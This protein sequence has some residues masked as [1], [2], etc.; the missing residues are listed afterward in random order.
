M[1]LN[2]LIEIRKSKWNH[3]GSK[4]L[5]LTNVDLHPNL[6]DAGQKL[7]VLEKHILE[8]VPLG[9]LNVYLEVVDVGAQQRKA[10]QDAAEVGHLEWGSGVSVTSHDVMLLVT[11]IQYHFVESTCPLS[12]S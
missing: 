2:V 3:N 7:P 9:A 10:V 4:T 12:F 5:P 11:M 8:E 6:L 1:T